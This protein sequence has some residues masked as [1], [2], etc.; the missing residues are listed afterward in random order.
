MEYKIQFT[1]KPQDTWNVVVS[2]RKVRKF[3]VN[4]RVNS[5]FLYIIRSKVL[6]RLDEKYL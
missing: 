3:L 2:D 1:I 6:G 5:L 4:S